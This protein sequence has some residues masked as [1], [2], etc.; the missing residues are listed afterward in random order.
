MASH[1]VMLSHGTSWSS[2]HS[3]LHRFYIVV[4]SSVSTEVAFFAPQQIR[5]SAGLNQAFSSVKWVSQECNVQSGK[6]KKTF[7]L[8]N[9]LPQAAEKHHINP[10]KLTHENHRNSTPFMPF[11][12]HMG[13][14]YSIYGNSN[15]M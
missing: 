7:L 8:K 5:H 6:T 9:Q 4:Y 3:L 13:S 10:Y 1:Y 11:F 2:G 15:M 12:I 14:M